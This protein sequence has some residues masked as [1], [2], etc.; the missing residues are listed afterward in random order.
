[1]R[2]DMLLLVIGMGV[3]TYITRRFFIGAAKH[4]PLH[5]MVIRLLEY[6][7]VAV[8][9]VLVVPAIVAPEQRLALSL[10]NVFIIGAA[11]TA[12]GLFLFKKQWLAIMLGVV[13]VVLIRVM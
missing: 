3:V 6:V 8:L 2:T 9:S 1:M 12:L 4:A 13:T 10:S 11:A 5:P 7:P